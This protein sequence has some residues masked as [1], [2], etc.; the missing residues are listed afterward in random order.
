MP[1][2]VYALK[3]ENAQLF[4]SPDEAA[5][6]DVFTEGGWPDAD[7]M[8]R[9][10]KFILAY[11]PNRSI[12][13]TP[14]EVLKTWRE[15]RTRALLR[16]ALSEASRVEQRV[17]DREER[18]RLKREAAAVA[19]A[20]R[21]MA[22]ARERNK[23]LPRSLT[24]G[25]SWPAAL[26]VCK[27]E[28]Y[29]AIVGAL[30]CG[31]FD[32]GCVVFAEAAQK[33]LGGDVVVMTRPSD[34][35]ADH[36]G[37]L[38]NGQFY[39]AD[40]MS[41]PET[42]MRKFADNEGVDVPTGLRPIAAEDLPEA[43]RNPALVERVADIL[44]KALGLSVTSALV[45][46]GRPMQEVLDL[47]QATDDFAQATRDKHPSL[48]R[49]ELFYD[50]TTDTMNLAN[51]EVY[52]S[53]RGHGV[54]SKVVR[55]VMDF[56]KSKGIKTVLTPQA[57]KKEDQPRLKRF[58][59][60]L[61][62]KKN[63]DPA[64]SDRLIAGKNSIVFDFDGTIAEE[65]AGGEIGKPIEATIELMRDAK[66]AGIEVIIQSARWAE[67][68]GVSAEQIDQSKADVAAWL[69]E[70][71]VP[72][73]RL[74]AGKDKAAAYFDD[75][76][77]NVKDP[78]KL[79]T[80][81]KE[82]ASGHP[83]DGGLR[84]AADSFA[85]EDFVD[86][87]YA[88]YPL[89][90]GEHGNWDEHVVDLG[91]RGKVYF[92]IDV[93]DDA[94]YV[95]LRWIEAD[96]SGEGLGTEVL[97]TLKAMAKTAG[98]DLVLEVSTDMR[99][100]EA[101]D[102]LK[103]WYRR[104]GFRKM[105]PSESR[106]SNYW[107]RL[108]AALVVE[109]ERYH[110]KDTVF[111]VDRGYILAGPK[112]VELEL[113]PTLD[114][115][116]NHS[117]DEKHALSKADLERPVLVGTLVDADGNTY[118]RIIDGN[119]RVFRAVQE[120]KPFR[121]K[122][123][124]LEET[125][126]I[127][128]DSEFIQRMRLAAA[129]DEGGIWYHGGSGAA[130]RAIAA[131]G[132][133]RRSS[134]NRWDEG[135][136]P[137]RGRVY[138]TR[139]P[140]TAIHYAE[141]AAIASIPKDADHTYDASHL[142]IGLVQLEVTD[143]YLP[144][145]DWLGEEFIGLNEACGSYRK[146]SP[147]VGALFNAGGLMSWGIAQEAAAAI[148]RTTFKRYEDVP[149]ATVARIG[150]RLIKELQ[151]RDPALLKKL[152]AL[153]PHVAVKPGVVRVVKAWVAKLDGMPSDLNTKVHT[154]RDQKFF[155]VAQELP[156]TTVKAGV[157]PSRFMAEL[158]EADPGE[159]TF[160]IVPA[161]GS[162]PD[163]AVKPAMDAAAEMAGLIPMESLDWS[164]TCLDADTRETCD[165]QR[166]V[167]MAELKERCKATL[168]YHI[169]L[170]WPPAGIEGHVKK[171][172][173][174]WVVTNKAGDKTL[175]THDSK[176]SADKQLAAIEIH[177]HMHG[178]LRL[179]AGETF[180]YIGIRYDVT[181]AKELVAGR[182]TETDKPTKAWIMPM[183][184]VDKKHAMTTDLNEPVIFAKI[185]LDGQVYDFLIDGHH[186]VSRAIEE[187]KSVQIQK[188][189]L[190]ESL[191][192][193][194]GPA[195]AKIK[196]EAKKL[197]LLKAGLWAS[198]FTKAELEGLG[199]TFTLVSDV[200]ERM[201]DGVIHVEYR[202]T[203]VAALGFHWADTL[204]D[205]AAIVPFSAWVSED[206]Q[207]MGLATA[208]YD[209]AE[210]TAGASMVPSAVRSDDAKNFWKSRKDIRHRVKASMIDYPNAGLAPD[211]FARGEDGEDHILPAAAED[212]RKTVADILEA[213][214]IH[215][216]RWVTRLLLGSSIAT[217]FYNPTTDVDVKVEVD[218]D[219]FK[220]SNP[221][222]RDL[223]E[224]ELEA[225]WDELMWD[226]DREFSLG[227]RPYEIRLRG[228]SH[229]ATPEDIENY[230]A[231]YDVTNDAWVKKAPTVDPSTYERKTTVAPAIKE[232]VKTAQAWDVLLGDIRRNLSELELLIQ[233]GVTPDKYAEQRL[234][235]VEKAAKKL[236][237]AKE[238]VREARGAAYHEGGDD[239]EFINAHPDI[240]KQ[241]L[242]VRWGYFAAIKPLDHYLEEHDPLT[243]ADVMPL[244]RAM[245]Y[246]QVI[247]AAGDAE[248]P[249]GFNVDLDKFPK[250]SSNEELTKILRHVLSKCNLGNVYPDDSPY[251]GEDWFA[252]G[253]YDLAQAI[254]KWTGGEAVVWEVAPGM[255]GPAPKS[256]S[257]AS[258]EEL[259]EIRERLEWGWHDVAFW[260]GLFWDAR[261]SYD[262][263]DLLETTGRHYDWAVLCPKGYQ[264]DFGKLRKGYLYNHRS[265]ELLA[266]GSINAGKPIPLT[267]R[268]EG[269]IEHAAEAIYEATQTP[270]R[271]SLQ[272]SAGL[273]FAGTSPGVL[274]IHAANP[275]PVE[276]P[277][278]EIER[279][280]KAAIAAYARNKTFSG[281]SNGWH[282][283]KTAAGGLELYRFKVVDVHG[284]IAMVSLW[285][286]T[287]TVANEPAKFDRDPVNSYFLGG[288]TYPVKQKWIEHG[289]EREE[290]VVVLH[291]N[292]N[293]TLADRRKAANSSWLPYRV[294]QT[295]EHELRHHSQ[296][297]PEKR[298]PGMP[299]SQP[300]EPLNEGEWPAYLNNPLEF[301]SRLGDVVNDFTA[302][303][304]FL[305]YPTRPLPASDTEAIEQTLKHTAFDFYQKHMTPEH[306]KKLRQAVATAYT[307]W[308]AEQLAN[309]A[310]VD[311]RYKE[312][313]QGER[314]TGLN[315]DYS[316]WS[317]KQSVAREKEKVEKKAAE[318]YRSEVK[319]ADA[320]RAPGHM[321]ERR[322]RTR[323]YST[324]TSTWRK[325]KSNLVF[326]DKIDELLK[327]AKAAVEDSDRW[328]DYDNNPA[329]ATQ[330]G[331]I[332]K[333]IKDAR[334]RE[335]LQVVWDR[336]AIEPGLDTLESEAGKE[337]KEEK[338][339]AKGK[340]EE[341]PE[342]AEEKKD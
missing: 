201:Q 77:I 249:A 213:T 266:P 79:G 36:A 116:G 254:V 235:E 160:T 182:P 248:W 155:K 262:A 21:A 287:H 109:A 195:A 246:E 145:E 314:Y 70:H 250:V 233:A 183:V 162:T 217:Q 212:I 9:A 87:V 211:V 292:R 263:E 47:E 324:Q 80:L 164:W 100:G 307:K 159:F 328:A 251:L 336:Y 151:E 176:E 166:K 83:V 114:M 88:L 92:K 37:V 127:A 323:T 50:C 326:A 228:A 94:D 289:V 86:E 150:K 131:E 105:K 342:P 239:L 179:Y 73:D 224:T 41:D 215:P 124:G 75:K 133:L 120:G 140:L 269:G 340:A 186:R 52:P 170:V 171:R 59:K 187:G 55:E 66:D 198:K 97:N 72:Y 275:V 7:T 112:P 308:K 322:P 196:R 168:A 189:T 329:L 313:A 35:A 125:L 335:D 126:S 13:E 40:G 188:L 331:D 16:T 302:K 286:T 49:L 152:A 277:K 119:H 219:G 301:E 264:Q 5:D 304:A 309:T 64:I 32:G 177:K 175:G 181:K 95:I 25:R 207:R 130:I 244:T 252:G 74:D 42:A 180:D 225:V 102:E 8:R 69:E 339:P 101:K 319:K 337:V 209:M 221:E 132:R 200:K 210:S 2:L 22:Q 14:P 122:V 178:A 98:I 259:E 192:I 338:T 54:G 89:A 320:G 156:V 167:F 253:C 146:K 51:I 273:T 173:S 90:E 110:Y 19:S 341:K 325:V 58:Y 297:H 185:V 93:A 117:I 256:L 218:V 184:Y 103:Q 157:E 260:H 203:Q 26:R 108:K 99:T 234:A 148:E 111:D 29:S 202:G 34:G 15:G 96:P 144:D 91:A 123:L 230:D 31:P 279:G 165:A 206:H 231:L 67:G 274:D 271:D 216:Q 27:A 3:P 113:Y 128:S 214:Y 270:R 294:A 321:P 278:S 240:V 226:H 84:A 303:L 227:E 220:L 10:K 141:T 316:K 63:T 71:D 272:V 43:P 247:E 299:D 136:A 222:Y 163:P 255:R 245:G 153:A 17:W 142:E 267:D 283:L 45:F 276:I 205:T 18:Y 290:L 191:D 137:Q 30:D 38:L 139:N 60:G 236:V 199:Y 284:N 312:L 85:C 11:H 158:R 243:M 57:P 106:D 48:S 193:A 154:P 232:A 285:A 62:F 334:S 261:G 23:D 39:D 327:L 1:L 68:D 194:S 238:A 190:K 161:D 229:F 242:L 258:D 223:S 288:L 257:A 20:E 237:A 317:I 81:I 46:A 208:M 6:F 280:A 204:G 24:S 268:V 296:H 135:A 53:Q 4:L 265:G 107:M 12:R 298:A 121:Y 169:L 134:K 281:T 115:I 138:L 104:H 28:L 76:A 61:G 149:M 78:K 310:E 129:A 315:E 143:E 56:A 282:Y 333:G 174:K 300:G 291:F 241:K 44:R 318:K 33:V 197:G 295:L 65:L 332:Q 305:N 330:L 293:R 306:V 172:G 118:P 311:K 147:E 82:L